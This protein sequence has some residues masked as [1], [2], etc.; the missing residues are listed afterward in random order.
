MTKITVEQVKELNEKQDFNKYSKCIFAVEEWPSIHPSMLNK[1]SEYYAGD[2]VVEKR[3]K[4]ENVFSVVDLFED[5][6]VTF[7]SREALL[8][9]YPDTPI[10]MLHSNKNV[11]VKYD[12][13]ESDLGKAVLATCFQFGYNWLQG[14]DTEKPRAARKVH[15]INWVLI[16]QNGQVF[17]N[18]YGT[19]R[20]YIYPQVNEWTRKLNTKTLYKRMF[21]SP[22]HFT[23]MHEYTWE[24]VYEK[25][26]ADMF[27]P[28]MYCSNEFYNI[29]KR[30]YDLFN[31]ILGYIEPKLK[32]GAKQNAVNEFEGLD[33]IEN[34]TSKKTID[35]IADG[36]I[37]CKQGAK[38][39]EY[40]VINRLKSDKDIILIR[41][42]F[43]GSNEDHARMYITKKAIYS[44]FKS[45]YG[46]WIYRPMSKEYSYG[47]NFAI[48]DFDDYG[49]DV[50]KGTLIEYNYEIIKNIAKG[51]CNSFGR[52]IFSLLR[53][54]GT[55][56]FL[57]TKYAKYVDIS[58][59]S[60]RVVEEMFGKTNPR[61][62]GFFR[63]VGMTKKQ[64]DFLFDGLDSRIEEGTNLLMESFGKYYSE[65]CKFSLMSKAIECI[66]KVFAPIELGESNLGY[67]YI[68]ISHIDKET[69]ESVVN[70]FFKTL[71]HVG[72]TNAAEP[73]MR[74]VA[75]VLRN[76]RQ[77]Y[78]ANMFKNAVAFINAICDKQ[79]NVVV[80]RWTGDSINVDKD[81]LLIYRDYLNMLVDVQECR[82][83]P[84]KFKFLSDIVKAHDDF[85]PIY[86][87]IKDKQR[88]PE[89]AD[90]E[91]GELG[92]LWDKFKYEDDNFILI[93]P[94]SA[95]DIYKEGR[96][97]R[98]CVGSFVPK[99]VARETNIF[100][101]RRKDKP[102][103][104]FYTLEFKQGVVRQ[105]HGMCNRNA[106]EVPGLDDFISKWAKEKKISYPKVR[107]RSAL[108]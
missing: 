5:R 23:E 46:Y 75:E 74:N 80:R 62:K 103:V 22:V 43:S 11:K 57:K 105:V 95:R 40:A 20:E 52:T 78:G 96:E 91:I 98:H 99:V 38:D 37:G 9:D 54:T 27:N 79:V 32:S 55:E 61:K 8:R 89:L 25:Y 67:T 24:E 70:V 107:A 31:Y 48:K 59:M 87:D 13:I 4:R 6:V 64:L 81:I 29:K 15:E 65:Y 21:G 68:D 17:S 47:Y 39:R 26:F 50:F 16:F 12:K 33:I 94:T 41:R 51:D 14:R 66:K 106:D 102:N 69:Y 92:V 84:W 88:A 56:E 18:A 104:P 83:Y 60:P 90:K 36:T 71:D 72:L 82:N 35:L 44:S 97:L 2:E 101:I 86:N 93:Y 49:K 10:S 30:Q 1:D 19:N 77:Y 63:Q 7:A 76:F 85:I 42:F 3:E 73:S 58:Q 28:V 100:F 53:S 45:R 34:M 108:A